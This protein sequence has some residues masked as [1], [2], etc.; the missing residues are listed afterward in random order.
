LCSRPIKGLSDPKIRKFWGI[1]NLYG[2]ITTSQHPESWMA[3]KCQL[4]KTFCQDVLE[5]WE[6]MTINGGDDI[7]D[8]S[9]SMGP[10][11][12]TQHVHI[13]MFFSQR[14]LSND[15]GPSCIQNGGSVAFFHLLMSLVCA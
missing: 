10:Q 6:Q 8:N 7:D 13:V 11:K 3:R 12:F 9:R 14:L 1:L 15:N 5:A 2:P 4:A